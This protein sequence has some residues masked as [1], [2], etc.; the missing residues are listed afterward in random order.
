MNTSSRFAELR[1]VHQVHVNGVLPHN[2]SDVMGPTVHRALAKSVPQPAE[3]SLVLQN[4]G[5]R[6]RYC[7]TWI[8]RIG[9]Y[10]RPAELTVRTSRR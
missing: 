8:R 7:N 4:R 3:D 1:Q 5:S 6:V 2:H 10:D 9:G